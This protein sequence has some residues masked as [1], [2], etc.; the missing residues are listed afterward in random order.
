MRGSNQNP[1]SGGPLILGNSKLITDPDQ[2]IPQSIINPY[3]VNN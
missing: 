1:I 3:S 2:E